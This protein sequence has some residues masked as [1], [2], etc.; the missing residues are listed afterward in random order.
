MQAALGTPAVVS[1]DDLVGIA[2]GVATVGNAD[3]TLTTGVGV[4][5]TGD[6]VENEPAAMYRGASSV[7][8]GG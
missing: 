6:D 2:Y 3:R 5:Y 4:C 8:A 7:S 1:D